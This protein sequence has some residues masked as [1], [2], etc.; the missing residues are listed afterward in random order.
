MSTRA[1]AD[2]GAHVLIPVK[3]LARAK[4]RL[5][6]RLEPIERR[7]L[8]LAMLEDTLAAAA[9]SP[10]VD[11]IT[12]V[13]PDAAAARL[14][15]ELGIGVLEEATLTPTAE[16]SSPLNAALDA[17]ARQIRSASPPATLVVLQADLPALRAQELTA[18]IA[19][20]AGDRAVVADFAGIGTTALIVPAADAR[21]RP[22]FG[23]W[24]ARE[25]QRGGAVELTG[26]WPG[27]RSDVDTAEDLR[28]AHS[29]GVGRATAAL[30]D[31]LDESDW[32]TA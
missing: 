21:L 11:R 16:D 1:D 25:H 15:R 14:A 7:L 31:A 4:S 32:H 19:Q 6:P 2:S 28:R 29:L 27:L 5:A 9:A 8:A 30:L 18:A 22:R 10:L 12:V 20:A 26:D 3:R 17:A 13:T 23:P 24:S